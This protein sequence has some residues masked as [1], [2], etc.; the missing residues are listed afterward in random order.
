V[1]L[2]GRSDRHATSKNWNKVEHCRTQQ[3]RGFVRSDRLCPVGFARRA[4]L[5]IRGWVCSDGNLPFPRPNSAQDRTLT[6]Q[7]DPWLR[8][9][10][11]AQTNQR[12]E[13]RLWWLRSAVL[14]LRPLGSLGA[15]Q[16]RLACFGSSP[17]G[18]SDRSTT[19]HHRDHSEARSAIPPGAA[20]EFSISHCWRQ[21][22]H[23][24]FCMPMFPGFPQSYVLGRTS[25]SVLLHFP[26]VAA[27]ISDVLAPGKAWERRKSLELGNLSSEPCG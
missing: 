24:I 19:E 7:S 20:D 16:G 5:R 15:I 26:Q 4:T 12:S 14:V 13:R 9:A 27:T 11:A 17:R 3:R 8:A 1:G 18:L 2:I 6:L 21:H 23:S 25:S 22:R 10:R